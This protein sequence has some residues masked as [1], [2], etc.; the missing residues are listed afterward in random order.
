MIFL[1]GHVL[2]LSRCTEN[3]GG[4]FGSKSYVLSSSCGKDS[5]TLCIVVFL[6]LF[7][8][9]SCGTNSYPVEDGGFMLC[10]N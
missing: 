10:V 9:D 3:A 4:R 1:R 2:F 5:D 8:S 6:S 7:F